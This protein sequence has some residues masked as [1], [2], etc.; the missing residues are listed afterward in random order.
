MW[1]ILLYILCL[2]YLLTLRLPK[3]RPSASL[4]LIDL[5]NM[6]K[7]H[8]IEWRHRGRRYMIMLTT[9]SIA[10]PSR[11]RDSTAGIPNGIIIRHFWLDG[12]LCN[13]DTFAMKNLRWK[14]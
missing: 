14:V 3:N 6:H 13:T 12:K 11:N 1:F 5:I 2:L 10:K 7:I 8:E 4:Q 9:K